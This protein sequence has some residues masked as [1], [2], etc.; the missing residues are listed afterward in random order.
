[1]SITTP[2]NRLKMK[3]PIKLLIE[4]L[5]R[6]IKINTLINNPTLQYDLESYLEVV[7]EYESIERII[8]EN[9]YNNAKTYPSAD[10]DGSKY[11]FMNYITN[12]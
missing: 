2:K 4:D 10:C 7:K 5:Q 11:Y 9:A 3:T 6:K 1:M 12:D 8:I